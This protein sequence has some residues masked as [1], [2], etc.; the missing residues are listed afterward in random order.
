MSMSDPTRM[1]APR[2]RA[3][4]F[5]LSALLAV[6]A[7]FVFVEGDGFRKRDLNSHVLDIY[8]IA[9]NKD[10][11]AVADFSARHICFIGEDGYVPETMMIG[12]TVV[13]SD[14]CYCADL[15]CGF[16]SQRI[17]IVTDNCLIYGFY[18]FDWEFANGSA[19]KCYA[20]TSK[21][22]FKWRKFPPGNVA[23]ESGDEE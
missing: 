16:M 12:N 22:T 23:D 4:S 6:A 8:G 13:R 14:D 15:L 2:R 20:G 7:V 17:I 18:D 3:S 10:K 19:R 11:W 9:I 1:R 21:A 5:L